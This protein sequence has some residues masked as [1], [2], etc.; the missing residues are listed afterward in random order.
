MLNY[1]VSTKVSEK[2]ESITGIK[3]DSLTELKSNI[4]LATFDKFSVSDEINL[5]LLKA[6]GID[7]K[8]VRLQSCKKN[9]DGKQVF[10]FMVNGSN[11]KSFYKAMVIEQTDKKPVSL[12]EQKEPVSIVP[13]N[14]D[15]CRPDKRTITSLVTSKPEQKAVEVQTVKND[16]NFVSKEQFD[17]LQAKFDLVIEM[18]NKQSKK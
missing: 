12:K 18:L 10:S 13:K 1:N 2:F 4:Q 8:F 15:N 7:S 11:V 3:L 5:K 6:Q 14:A 9:T 16:E 17:S